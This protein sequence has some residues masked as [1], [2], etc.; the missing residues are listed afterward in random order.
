RVN[1]LAPAFL[2]RRAERDAQPTESGFWY[3]LSR[4]VMRRP[5][6]IAVAS[7]TFLIALG[8]PFWGIKFTSVDASVLPT[9]A[10]A[11]QVDTAMKNDFPPHRDLPIQLAVSGADRA[12]LAKLSAAARHVSG[13]AAVDPP[14][15]LTGGVSEIG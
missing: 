1:A 10:S 8:I 11:R 15:R 5:A 2:Q 3:R 14:E 7:A 6:A 12:Q 13:V 4:F 9:S